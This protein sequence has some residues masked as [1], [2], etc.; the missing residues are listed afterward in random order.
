MTW[1][2]TFYLQN[3]N[4]LWPD[5]NFDNFFQYGVRVA[6]FLGLGLDMMMDIFFKWLSPTVGDPRFESGYGTT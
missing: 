2:L 4:L 3:F 5:L 6:P 1:K